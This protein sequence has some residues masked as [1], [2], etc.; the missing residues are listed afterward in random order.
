VF[1]QQLRERGLH[2]G[3]YHVQ[4]VCGSGSSGGGAF[5]T[6]LGLS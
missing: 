5:A 6:P 3:S 4:D 1:E 2:S